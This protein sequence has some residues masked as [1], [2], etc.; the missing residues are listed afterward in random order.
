MSVN[1]VH[2][3]EGERHQAP[4]ANGPVAEILVGEAPGRQMGVVEVTVP[5]CGQM[6]L[7]DHGDSESLLI[8]LHGAI[9]LVGEAGDGDVTVLEPGVIVT[10]PAGEKVRLDNPE[11]GE[12]RLLVVFSPA[13]FTGQVATWPLA[14]AEAPAAAA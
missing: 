5:C 12:G 2:L 3:G 4:V 9:R 11:H 7:H 8:P 1:C 6:G 10:I 13:S 14:E